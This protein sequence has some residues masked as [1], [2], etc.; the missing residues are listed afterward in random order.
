MGL[1][2]EELKW[3]EVNEKEEEENPCNEPESL[4]KRIKKAIKVLRG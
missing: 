1:S 3:L 2:A 4:P